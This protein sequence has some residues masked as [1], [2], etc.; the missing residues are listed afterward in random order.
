MRIQIV[1]IPS[2]TAEDVLARFEQ[3]I[4]LPSTF[5]V[6]PVDVPLHVPL[7]VSSADDRDLGLQ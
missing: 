2:Q 6:D 7:R 3:H 4:E 1:E 5:L